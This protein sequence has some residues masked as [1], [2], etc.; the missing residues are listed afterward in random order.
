MDYPPPIVIKAEVRRVF[1]PPFIPKP[2]VE[3]I[4]PKTVQLPTA[5]DCPPGAS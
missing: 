4:I 2:K 5:I 1:P 3:E